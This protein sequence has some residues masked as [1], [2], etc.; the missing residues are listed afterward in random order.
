MTSQ[1]RS[2]IEYLIPTYIL[3]LLHSNPA[4]LTGFNTIFLVSC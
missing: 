2:G 4:L 3:L 1:I